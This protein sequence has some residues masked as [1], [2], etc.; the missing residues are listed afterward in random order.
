[1]AAFMRGIC[2]VWRTAVDADFRIL[3]RTLYISVGAAAGPS[4][5]PN[6]TFGC[7]NSPRACQGWQGRVRS[8][9]SS[10]LLLV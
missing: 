7:H 6:R 2:K 9:Q 1:M 5:S 3:Y 10:W 4:R 8:P